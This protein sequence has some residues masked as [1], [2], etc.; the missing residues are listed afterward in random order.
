MLIEWRAGLSA[1]WWRGWIFIMPWYLR[2]VHTG[3]TVQAVCH[4]FPWYL[5][6]NLQIHIIVF[7]F[8]SATW[9]TLA[10]SSLFS[11]RYFSVVVLWAPPDLSI[12]ADLH[13]YSGVMEYFCW[14]FLSHHRKRFYPCCVPLYCAYCGILHSAHYYGVY[15]YLGFYIYIILW[16]AWPSH[17]RLLQRSIFIFI[18]VSRTS[19][20][21]S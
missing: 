21:E 8:C 6:R 15:I 16:P 12:F 1:S 17:K 2:F 5:L 4:L 7:F 10:S 19:I 3:F 11:D 9:G 18:Y 13:R 14:T 20:C